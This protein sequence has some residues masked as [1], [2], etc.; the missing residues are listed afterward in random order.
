MIEAFLLSKIRLVGGV[1]LVVA[2]TLGGCGSPVGLY[3][4]VQGGAIDQPRQAPPGADLPYPNLASV[5]AAPAPLTKLQQ[6][7]LAARLNENSPMIAATEPNPVALAGLTLPVAPPPTPD[8]PGL[9]LPSSASQPA[10]ARRIPSPPPVAP[11]KPH[12]GVPLAVGFQPGSAILSNAMLVQIKRFCAG[13]GSANIL[14]GGFGEQSAEV[15]DE[16]S[17]DLAL[18][19]ARAIADALTADGVPPGVIVLNAAAAGSGGFVQLVY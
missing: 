6:D 19:R 9:S 4:D 11:P 15:P 14:A 16:G 12:D 5:P 2:L 13:R 17:L 10:A 7:A 18:S 1:L 3:H 8:L